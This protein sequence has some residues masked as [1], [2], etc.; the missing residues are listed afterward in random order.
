MKYYYSILG[1]D[2]ACAVKEIR[3]AYRR[4]A[5][6]Y[7]PDL[8]GDPSRFHDIR[9]AYEVLSDPR[10]RKEYDERLAG[11]PFGGES[12]KTVIPNVISEP[13]DVFDDAVDVLARRFGIEAKKR[14][15]ADIILD[16]TEAREGVNLQLQ[17]PSEMICHR[18]FGFGG[19]LISVCRHCGGTGMITGSRIAC[20][21]IPAGVR[22]GEVIVSRAGRIEILGRIIIEK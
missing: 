1:V 14:I 22:Q 18:C 9:A 6:K 8:G 15:K 12:Y 5:K 17:L 19:T 21:T 13:V 7:H 10:S 2:P 4:L 16:E 3:S 11:L 20:V